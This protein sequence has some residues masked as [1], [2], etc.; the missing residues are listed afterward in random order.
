MLYQLLNLYA[1]WESTS[2]T[3]RNVLILETSRYIIMT[4]IGNCL[5]TTTTICSDLNISLSRGDNKILLITQN[6]KENYQDEYSSQH[7]KNNENQRKGRELHIRDTCLLHILTHWKYF[8]S[9]VSVH[10]NHMKI[11]QLTN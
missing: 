5:W 11:C 6:T 10:F 9:P 8:N 3:M 7:A 2:M 1:T 4:N